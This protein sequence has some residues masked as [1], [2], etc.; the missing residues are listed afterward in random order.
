MLVLLVWPGFQGIIEA[1]TGRFRLTWQDDPATTMVIGWDQISGSG[2]KVYYDVVNPGPLPEKFAFSK[3]PDQ[4]YNYKGMSNHFVRLAGLRPNTLYYFLVED[5]EGVSKVYSFK[6]APN[7]STD[8]LSIIAGSDSRNHRDA[9][10]DAN[11]LVAKLRPHFVLFGGDFTENDS[12][13]E[14][15]HWFDDWQNTISSDGR[16]YPIVVARGNH[17]YSNRTVIELFD[18]RNKDV[19]YALTFG[20]DL[21]R[22]YTLNSMIA[23]GGD[24]KIWLQKDLAE[25]P[26]IT[27]KIAQYHLSTR[28]HTRVK[29]SQNAQWE[30]W[31][32]IFYNYG[33]Q[34]AIESDAHVVKSTWPIR[35]STETGS[36]EG[37]I[38]DDLSGT[39]YIGEGCWGAPLR[40]ADDDK[41]WTRASGSFNCF[42]WIFVDQDG[43]EVR[44]VKTDGADYVKSINPN[45]IFEPPLGLNIW[46][47][48]NGDVIEIRRD[49]EELLADD[50]SQDALVAR[51]E[52]G[53]EIEAGFQILDFEVSRTGSDVKVSWQSLNE[54][55]RMKYELFRSIDH[56]DYEVVEIIHG[57]GK[58]EN[59]YIF[60]DRNFAELNPGKYVNYRLKQTQLEGS[61]DPGELKRRKMELKSSRPGIRKNAPPAV[62]LSEGGDVLV[63]FEVSKPG[64]CFARLLSL[65]GEVKHW[66]FNMIKP[67]SY[68]EKLECENVP[69]G[70]YLLVI[71]QGEEVLQRYRV[72]VE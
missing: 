18:V 38:R 52:N 11:K 68:I 12:E 71:K 42:H 36:E 29:D 44:F 58:K 33:L 7:K 16:M 72:L 37:F 40:R 56:G 5:S 24:Q 46:N 1:H 27:W 67:G 28:P 59:D 64:K 9:R 30:N 13:E 17:E 32:K 39:V 22:V 25:N 48:D 69:P 20:E 50:M 15:L 66:D 19:T 14:W 10:V 41:V 61:E 21:L 63:H 70:K 49:R 26:H 6:T 62:R 2:G 4:V 23:S 3:T 60:V 51:G 31:S 43:I 65:K 55:M 34:L 57:E 8:R 53:V 47:P 54:P 35:P 45:N